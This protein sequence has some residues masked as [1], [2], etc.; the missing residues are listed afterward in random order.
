MKRDYHISEEER[1]RRRQRLA[2]VRNSALGGKARWQ[3][4][5]PQKR[6]GIMSNVRT[7]R[8]KYASNQ[9]STL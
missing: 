8:G 4:I 3:N 5:A 7:G 9:N 2:E 6:S 1:A